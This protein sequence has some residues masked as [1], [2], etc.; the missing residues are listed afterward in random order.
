MQDANNS[1]AARVAVLRFPPLSILTQKIMAV[2]RIVQPGPE[3]EMVPL[4]LFGAMGYPDFPGISKTENITVFFLENPSETAAPMPTFIVLA[5]IETDSPARD[6]IAGYGLQMQDRDDGWVLITMDPGAFDRVNDVSPLIAAARSAKD[7]DIELM[8]ELDSARIERWMQ[9]LTNDLLD[10]V[11][12]ELPEGSDAK[13][14]QGLVQ[15]FSTLMQ[16]FLAN[17][18]NAKMGMDLS[19]EAIG[20]GLSIQARPGT[21]EAVLFSSRAGGPVDVAKYVPADAMFTYVG[22]TEVQPWIDYMHS[23]QE[24]LQPHLSP[25]HLALL[26]N[27]VTE[28][29]TYLQQYS[30]QWAASTNIDLAI[31]QISG[32]FICGGDFTDERVVESGQRLFNKL[33]PEVLTVVSDEFSEVV[34]YTFEENVDAHD[35]VNIHR[36]NIVSDY[37][38]VGLD[39]VVPLSEQQLFLAVVAGNL[40]MSYSAEELKAFIDTVKAGNAVENSVAEKVQLEPGQA[41]HFLLDL[42]S[43]LKTIFDAVP[44]ALSAD[45]QKVFDALTTAQLDPLRGDYAYANGRLSVGID[46]PVTSI[47]K[48]AEIAR[49]MQQAATEDAVQSV[50]PV[51]EAETDTA[52]P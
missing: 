37:S 44:D 51:E 34:N 45:N 49:S 3:T 33:L 50:P 36:L 4:F 5:K 25:E 22:N 19:A 1:S 48:M 15:G 32:H 47:A 23:L 10:D 14:M 26:Q 9:P 24:R 11:A 52:A 31:G 12:S 39:E 13:Q 42:R 16:V 30:G 43:Y 2:A 8:I 35:D 27:M 7:Y 28:M 6:A 21:P 18:A 40:L 41:V 46:V 38:K 29:K 17:F 20:A